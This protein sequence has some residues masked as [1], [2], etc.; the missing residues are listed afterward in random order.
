MP[1]ALHLI[2]VHVL[3]IVPSLQL[4]HVFAIFLYLSFGRQTER[5]YWHIEY[6]TTILET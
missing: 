6:L 1:S 2:Q 5:V 3:I 4:F